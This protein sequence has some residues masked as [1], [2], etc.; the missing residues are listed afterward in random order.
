MRLNG[1]N[2]EKLGQ[3]QK[4]SREEKKRLH[5]QEIFYLD[6]PLDWPQEAEIA[7]IAEIAGKRMNPPLIC[8]RM[9]AENPEIMQMQLYE[10]INTY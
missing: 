9:K 8:K 2:S 3:T 7:E 6:W 5:E 1:V 4:A 10:T